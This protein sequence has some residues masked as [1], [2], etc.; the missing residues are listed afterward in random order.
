[1][2]P[3]STLEARI[4]FYYRFG[5][6]P[7]G[8]T[9]EQYWTRIG[10]DLNKAD[11]AF[12]NHKGEVEDEL[13]RITSVN[14]SPETK[15]RK[16]YAAMQKIRNL[17][18][19]ETKTAKEEKQ[20]AIKPNRSV[21]DV[22]KH[23]YGYSAQINTLFIALARTAG[24]EARLAYVAPRSDKFFYPGL[25]DPSEINDD[26]AW[27]RAEGREYWLDPGARYYPF[28]ILPW[29]ETETGGVRLSDA[30]G[31]I[32]HTPALGAS[33]AIIRRR[34]DLKMDADGSLNGTAEVDFTG[35]AGAARRTEYS[36]E[37]EAGRRKGLSD[38]IQQS[39]PTGSKFEITEMENWD[40]PEQPLIA[41][42]TLDVTTFGTSAGQHLIFP[43]SVFRSPVTAAFR[44][45]RRAND[46]LFPYPYEQDDDVKL[47]LPAGNTV[48]S[49]PL[50]SQFP[51][52]SSSPVS[53]AL[54]A[55]RNGETLE[56]TRKLTIKKTGFSASMYPTLRTFFMGVESGDNAQIVTQK[57][58]TA[59]H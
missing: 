1:M 43:E 24:F 38:E 21:A 12:M 15:L 18:V 26:I 57:T 45:E 46:I 19:E 54:N 41:K 16:I 4:A 50:A 33:D 9:T 10:K 14:D 17:S 59:Q 25:E 52:E 5:S 28:G 31:E 44:P 47:Q 51:P 34:A 55:T 22:L 39:L 58:Q 20:E 6:S 32:I 40:D 11:D 27:V 29:F 35:E 42:G 8:E 13:S 7:A 48:E 37:D 2:P 53:Y 36:E 49:M 23:G 30:G 56:I 3:E